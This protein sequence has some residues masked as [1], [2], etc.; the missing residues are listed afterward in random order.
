MSNAVIDSMSNKEIS[1]AWE[2][3]VNTKIDLTKEGLDEAVNKTTQK[4]ISTINPDARI[5]TILTSILD[6]IRDEIN[7]KKNENFSYYNIKNKKNENIQSVSITDI[8]I[9][10]ISTYLLQNNFSKDEEINLI[11]KLFEMILMDKKQ[12]K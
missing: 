4:F 3:V 5:L 6:D 10:K 8:V 9:P 7:N 12:T 2:D 11:V 1:E